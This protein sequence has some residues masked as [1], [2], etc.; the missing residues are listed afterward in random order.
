MSKK[1]LSCGSCNLVCPTCYCF[2]VTDRLQL[3]LKDGKRFRRWDSCQLDSFAAVATG[4]NF[5]TERKNRLKHRLNRKCLYETSDYGKPSCVGCGRC[6]RACVAG[7]DIKEAI[8][9]LAERH[10]A[11]LQG[12]L[13]YA[14]V[15]GR[16]KTTD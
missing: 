12:F 13:E 15:P 8:N 1:C 16:E 4:E 11:E 5:R 9:I 2:D 7:I 6:A 3:N 14:I 10:R